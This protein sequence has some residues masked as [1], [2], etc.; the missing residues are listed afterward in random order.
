MGAYPPIERL[1]IATHNPGKLREIQELLDPFGI[2]CVSAGSLNLP[3]PEETET[4]F[5]GNALLKARAATAGSGL[6]ALADDSG[7]AVTALGGEPGIYSA[8]WAGPTKD[9]SIAMA[10]VEARMAGKTDRSAKFI[11]ALAL[12]WPDGTEVVFEGSMPGTLVWPP[13]GENGFGYDPMVQ[14]LGDTRTCGEM[15]P[16]EKH[17]ISHRADAFRQLVAAVFQR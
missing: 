13:R 17:A 2:A 7:L 6:P 5:I 16:A 1:V 15:P 3:E 11:C 12:V 8:R 4:T 9:F 14:P 10:A